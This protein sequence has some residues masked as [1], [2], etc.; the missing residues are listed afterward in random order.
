MRGRCE[1]IRRGGRAR[2][3]GENEIS[4]KKLEDGDFDGS[5]NSCENT[6]FSIVRERIDGG[7]SMELSNIFR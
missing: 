3:G 7:T 2:N 6:I 1:M 4:K 5:F